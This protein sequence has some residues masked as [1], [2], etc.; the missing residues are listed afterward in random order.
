MAVPTAGIVFYH[1][2]HRNIIQIPIII[3]TSLRTKFPGHLPGLQL[4]RL[5][6]MRHGLLGKDY[7]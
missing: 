7:L 6:V 3:F 1:F 4:Y 2:V 5:I